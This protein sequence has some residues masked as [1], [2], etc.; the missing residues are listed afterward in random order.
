MAKLTD[1]TLAQSSA[2]T[3]TTLIHIVTTGDTSQ[4]SAGSSYKAELNQIAPTIGGYQYY[5]AVTVSSAQILTLNS[6]PVVVLPSLGTSQYYDFKMYFE[7][8]FGTTGYTGLTQVRLVD[9]SFNQISPTINCQTT[10][11]VVAIWNNNY[12]TSLFNTNVILYN[13]SDPTNGDGNIK[14]KI[15]YN[16]VN[17]G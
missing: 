4:D 13:A 6:S 8:D 12:T 17:F 7:Y 2:I 1:K 10:N 11:N 15:Y 16:L 3:P 5:T 14:L 9:D